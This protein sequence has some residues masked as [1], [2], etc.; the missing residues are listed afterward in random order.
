[1]RLAGHLV[2]L[3]G[4]TGK[5]GAAIATGLAA[6]GASVVRH[7]RLPR[8]G[9]F[10]GDLS[11]PGGAARL[12]AEVTA[13]HG[14]PL[15]VVNL[16]HPPFTPRSVLASDWAADWLP[17]FTQGVGAALALTQSVLPAMRAA[18]F[19][20][21]VHVS[22]GLSTRPQRNCGAYATSKAALNML[23]RT[24]AVEH[25]ADGV[26]VN[27]VAPG[28]I[29][30][31]EEGIAA[32]ASINAAQRTTQAIPGVAHPGDVAAAIAGFLD[33]AARFV[34]GQTLFLNGGQVMP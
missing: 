4:A 28:E 32:Y 9:C 20:R 10:A 2:L 8:P 24:T 1:M 12:L 18:R 14:T 23:A 3:A 25:G 19:G 29:R 27:I 6:E 11:E 34:T 5:I 17:H 7:G 13:Q 33:P 26:T 30:E 16:V 31:A 21:I 15:M 22:G